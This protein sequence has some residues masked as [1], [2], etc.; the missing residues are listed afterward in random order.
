MK[1]LFE[2][3]EEKQIDS[4]PLSLNPMYVHNYPENISRLSVVTKRTKRET[5]FLFKIIVNQQH[6]STFND[7]YTCSNKK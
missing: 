7:W 1:E 6:Y 4:L 2:W 5:D 3:K